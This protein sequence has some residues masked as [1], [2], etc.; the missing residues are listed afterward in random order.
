MDGVDA[1]MSEEGCEWSEAAMSACESGSSCVMVE[2]GAR[3]VESVRG[4][5]QQC[6]AR[7][8]RFGWCA[9]C[10]C[11]QGAEAM[12]RVLSHGYGSSK[13]CG[14]VEGG[15]SVASR[16]ESDRQQTCEST[17]GHS[18]PRCERECCGC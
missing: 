5:C 12:S 8:R 15:M 3:R 6:T 16:T 17:D 9:V 4:A 7:E 14:G 18:R 10:G 2:R 13:S 1:A 11:V